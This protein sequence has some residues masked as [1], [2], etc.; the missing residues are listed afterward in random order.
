MFLTL[1]KQKIKKLSKKNS[2]FIILIVIIMLFYAGNFFVDYI[3]S[4]VI[5][6]ADGQN[7]YSIVKYYSDNIFPNSFGW[8]FNWNAGMPWPLGYNPF[9]SYLMAF[10]FHIIPLSATLIFKLFFIL[11]VF[12]LPILVYFIAK[13]LGF[14][15]SYSFLS[16]ILAIFF[17]VST[18]ARAGL[19]GST[20]D[21]TFNCGLYPQFFSSFLYLLWLYFFIDFD[22]NKLYHFL[23]V[24][25]FSLIFLSNTHVAEVAL[26]TF[27]IFAL[28]DFIFSKNLLHC[29][30]KYFFYAIISMGLIAF[31]ALPLLSTLDYFPHITFGKVP[32]RDV[33]GVSGVIIFL[34]VGGIVA[35]LRKKQHLI[36]LFLVFI[37]VM[38]L[39]MLPVKSVFPSLPLQP[40]RLFPL[41]YSFFVFLIPVIFVE[42]RKHIGLKHIFMLLTISL[43]VFVYY[44]RPLSEGSNKFFSLSSDIQTIEFLKTQEKGRSVLE[45]PSLPRS[46]PVAFNMAA[47]A[48]EGSKHETL[49]NVFR[50]SS[51]NSVFVAPLRNSFSSGQESFG[52]S[53]ML[54]GKS[55]AN[56]FYGQA[57]ENH[58]KR[59]E[60][61]NIKYFVVKSPEMIEL[62]L[63]FS[64]ND[65]TLL[66]VFD[67]WSL[68]PDI[69]YNKNEELL[70]IS[71]Q[72][73]PNFAPWYVFEYRKNI[74]NAYIPEYEPALVFTELKSKERLYQG[75]ESYNWLRI[76]E[77]WFL[78]ADFRTILVHPHDIYLDST[79][80]LNNFKVAIIEEYNYKDIDQAYKNLVDYSCD[81]KL[82]LFVPKYTQEPLVEMLKN[83]QNNPN[84]KFIQRVNDPRI[85]VK[86][87]LKVLDN[88]N[89]K[90]EHQ[91]TIIQYDKE[92]NNILI[93]LDDQFSGQNKIY[94]KNSYFPFWEDTRGGD[95]YM[96]SPVFQLVVTDND[97]VELEFNENKSNILKVGSF[98]SLISF[99]G[100]LGFCVLSKKENS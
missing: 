40:H 25:L 36:G 61:Y 64:S 23:S 91:N 71:K 16:A 93:Q 85:G 67:S 100:L 18:E 14:K 27:L 37:V 69:T 63:N 59:A 28:L 72:R 55:Q 82:V 26:I 21:S 66:K 8:V 75:Q 2:F 20:I 54:C 12:L 11:L 80:D 92:N 70:S 88:F 6:G 49:W 30:R 62:I 77:E 81:N 24:V 79:N 3:Q 17:L 90:I 53:C 76:A 35:L 33:A 7:H 46:Y 65:F 9:F 31:W 42:I 13:K 98:I 5:G 58:I 43:G 41:V 78:H 60:L 29:V 47:M 22:K 68:F 50:E 10:L 38:L 84:I 51:I 94:V 95:V 1:F 83:Q 89:L 45:I 52:V 19:L 44:F 97:S 34:L 56:D 99:V 32:F 15:K 4:N 39:I 96:A 74:S 87:L 48:G 73:E 57:F 86:Q